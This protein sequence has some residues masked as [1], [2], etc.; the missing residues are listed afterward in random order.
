MMRESF[1]DKVTIFDVEPIIMQLLIEFCY[2]GDV[3]ITI[4][5]VEPL[6]KAADLFQVSSESK[7]KPK[8]K[9]LCFWNSF[10]SFEV[11]IVLVFSGLC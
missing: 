10:C 1:T 2:T 5:N 4:E 6:L 8:T 11:C 3:E 7:T 9:K